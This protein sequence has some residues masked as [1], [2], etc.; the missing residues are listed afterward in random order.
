MHKMEHKIHHSS[1]EILGM[2]RKNPKNTPTLSISVC[3]NGGRLGDPQGVFGKRLKD[4]LINNGF[5]TG[6]SFSWA[7]QT[8]LGMV[9]E[10]K[11]GLSAVLVIENKFGRVKTEPYSSERLAKFRPSSIHR[12][13][14]KFISD[15]NL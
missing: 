10:Q 15:P 12:A 13:K 7:F 4:I 2:L 8:I 9:E 11:L 1:R 3:A 14:L 5:N 6:A